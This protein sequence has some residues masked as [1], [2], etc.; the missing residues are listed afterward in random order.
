MSFLSRILV[1]DDEPDILEL[2]GGILAPGYSVELCQNVDQAKD[3]L[4]LGP[5]DLIITDIAMPGAPGT[6]L[7]DY[8]KELDLSIPILVVSGLLEL[9]KYQVNSTNW[10]SKPFRRQE[11]LD[12]VANLIASNRS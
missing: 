12:K 3:Q 2:L 8:V 6:D 10:L 7:F 1:V 9:E 4:K 5:F 11:L